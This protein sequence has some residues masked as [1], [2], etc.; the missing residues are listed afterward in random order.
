MRV[1]MLPCGRLA[2]EE[3]R[4]ELEVGDSFSWRAADYPQTLEK[5]KVQP[6]NMTSY[7][8]VGLTPKRLIQVSRSAL[9]SLTKDKIR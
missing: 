2:L 8:I 5:W 7:A 4:L 1:I 6:K 3:R 9:Q